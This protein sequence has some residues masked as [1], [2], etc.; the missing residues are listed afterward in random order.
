MCWLLVAETIQKYIEIRGGKSLSIFFFK[1]IIANDAKFVLVCL[2]V[3]KLI[4]LIEKELK[5]IK[6]K[7]SISFLMV[8]CLSQYLFLEAIKTI[9]M[10]Q[11]A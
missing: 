1:V 4:K 6:N 9:E 7:T 11:K 10:Q 2:L 5:R 8:Y 3:H